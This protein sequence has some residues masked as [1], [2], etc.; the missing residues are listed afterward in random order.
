MVINITHTIYCVFSVFIGYIH[1]PIAT[2]DYYDLLLSLFIVVRAMS[3][4][5]TST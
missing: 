2:H 4:I 5:T 1:E 3:S